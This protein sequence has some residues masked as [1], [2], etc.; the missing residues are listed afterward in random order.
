MILNKVQSDLGLAR[1]D[2][3]QCICG[4]RIVCVNELFWMRWAA[5]TEAV[6]ACGG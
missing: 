2:L 1:T 3:E 5:V 6:C 4:W